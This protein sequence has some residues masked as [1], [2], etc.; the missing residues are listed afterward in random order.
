LALLKF[1]NT[2]PAF[3]FEAKLTVLPTEPHVLQL[4]WE[5]NGCRAT[6]EADLKAYTYQIQAFDESGCVTHT[7]G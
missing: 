2:C 5:N 7:F 3:G 6:L 4:H 1:R